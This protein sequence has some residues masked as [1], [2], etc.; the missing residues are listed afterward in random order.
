MPKVNI[1]NTFT[2]KVKKPTDKTKEMYFDNNEIGLVLEVRATGTKTFYYRY[3]EAGK[4][5]QRKL[6]STDTITADQARKLVKKLKQDKEKNTTITIHSSLAPKSTSSITLQEYWD[7]YY[8]PYIKTK[9]RS[10]KTDISFYTNHILPYFKDTPMSDITTH[11][12][13]LHHIDLVQKHKL[14]KSTANKLILFLSYAYNMAIEWNIAN[15]TTNPV[16]KVKH[17]IVDSS[18]EN[19]LDDVQIQRLLS[20]VDTYKNNI[21]LSSIVRFLLL[22]GARKNE[23]LKA[24]WKDIDL[25]HKIWTIPL[26]KSN[27][28]R[29]VP[30][31]SSLEKLILTI[32]RTNNPYIFPSP[33]TQQPMHDIF[34]HWNKVRNQANLPHIRIHDLRHTTASILVNKGVSLYQVQ[35]LLGHSN[36]K[37]TMRYAHLSNQALQDAVGVLDG[38]VG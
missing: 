16:A 37:M 21:N 9:K 5:H 31:S 22:T 12:L 1:T 34:K 7:S 13:T 27:K 8:L 30:I 14:E 23:V 11:Q 25:K 19:Y 36:I 24:K 35:K 17:Y 32:A 29:T 33:I 3:N 20:T 10:Y 15:I 18:I 26:S 6:A 38:V 2:K 28:S 4:T